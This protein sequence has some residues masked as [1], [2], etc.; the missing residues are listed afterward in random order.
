MFANFGPNGCYRLYQDGRL[1]SERQ[2]RFLCDTIHRGFVQNN[3]GGVMTA[4]HRLVAEHFLPNPRPA[5]YTVLVHVDGNV[6]NNDVSNL[7]WVPD[8]FYEFSKQLVS[9]RCDSRCRRNPF[10][11]R[12]KFKGR[13]HHLGMFETHEEALSVAHKIR[14]ELF[15]LYHMY[16]TEPVSMPPPNQWQITKHGVVT[17]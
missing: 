11:S 5:I 16:C 6:S 12:L 3:L 13:V 2:G 17:A 14:M 9:V 10:Q 1:Y 8:S 7:M 4:R 15:Y